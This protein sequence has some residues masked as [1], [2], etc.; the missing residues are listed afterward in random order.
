M[1]CLLFC[2]E[3][4]GRGI[5]K[6]ISYIVS[7]LLETYEKVD[8]YISPS[9][10]EGRKK[11]VEEASLYDSLIIAGGDGTFFYAVNALA[12]LE[13]RPN[14]GYINTGTL[15]D[16]GKNFGVSHSIKKALQ[17]IKEGKTKPVDLIQFNDSYFAYMAS[18]G[19][20]GDIAYS[21][22]KTFK[23]LFR[24]IHY[25]FMG[26][27]RMLRREEVVF[28]IEA[29]GGKIEGKAP[30]VLLANGKY[31]GGFSLNKNSSINDGSFEIIIPKKGMTNG[32]AS[33]L[34]NRKCRKIK[35]SEATISLPTGQNWCLDGEKSFAKVA[36]IVNLQGFLSVF[37][38]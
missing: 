15:G 32:I 27:I 28:S 1:K 9:I 22:R 33:A 26:M 36:K 11:I 34:F 10:E 25:Y 30:F 13:K 35:C 5:D 29:N 18:V 20:Y 31:V 38:R 24:K 16:V 7:S 4:A 17:I 37:S 19:A 3:F 23:R 21:A 6:K 12:T 8:V 14:I 2:T